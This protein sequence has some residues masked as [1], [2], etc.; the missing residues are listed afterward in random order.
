M[1]KIVFSIF[2]LTALIGNDFFWGVS[3]SEYQSSGSKTVNNSNWTQWEK[4]SGISSESSN[5]H[6]NNYQTHIDAIHDLGC[7]AF[8]FSLEWSMIEPKEGVFD[9][10]VIDHYREEI[11]ALIK[12]GITPMITMDHFTE[13]KWFT[14]KGSFEK[15]ENIAIFET[16]ATKV[17]SEYCDLVTFWAVINEPT[18]RS[19]MP[20]WLGDFP[21][22][23]KHIPTA[24]K[25]LK[26]LL[27][28]HVNVYTACKKIHP[29]A[30]IG[31]V[32][33][34][35]PFQPYSQNPL[36]Q[37]VA[38]MMTKNWNDGVIHFFQEGTL[39]LDI[40]FAGALHYKDLSATNAFD[41]VG[42]N[43][44]ATPILKCT[45]FKGDW[46]ISTCKEG[47]VMTDM[48]YHIDPEGFYN[49][50]LRCKEFQKPIYVTENG[51]ADSKDDRRAYY[52]QSYTDAMKRAM[53]EGVDIRGY[54]YWT[55]F[56]NFEWAYG[57][58]MQFGLYELDKET[59]EF[60]IKE[61]GKAY[62]KVINHFFD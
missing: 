40:P 21:P 33:S 19:F 32:H 13:P 57:Y 36:E 20:Y 56:D 24:F 26:H 41:F 11:K 59:F 8:R 9:Q 15:E 58:S 49:C 6:Y 45:P 61:G 7:N 39:D 12:N 34:Y 29:S 28:A 30:Q 38:K 25:V 22:H 43:Y 50:L 4:E 10:S 51:I 3:I 2:Y 52:I 60:E 35:L 31:F 53:E 48:P 27:I 46:F 16:Y 17:F 54:F 47:Q 62:K 55:L 37:M 44:Y 1:R 18:V 14:E 42:I 5:D 23:K